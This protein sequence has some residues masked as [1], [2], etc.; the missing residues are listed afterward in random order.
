MKWLFLLVLL[1][2]TPL[3]VALLREKPQ[4]ILF[5]G[6]LIGLAPFFQ[7]TLHLSAS[8]ISW[9]GWPGTV[10]GTEVTLLDAIAVAIILV[11]RPR[12]SPIMLKVGLGM[13]VVAVAISTL[14][15]S[16]MMPSLFYAWQLL[17]SVLVYVAVTRATA[18]Y[19]EFPQRILIGL[20]IGM[21]YEVYL[22]LLQRLHG[23]V[24]AGGSFGHQNQLGMITFFVVF[25]ALALLLA[26][27]R[28]RLAL[29]VVIAEL[30][31]AF[32][33][34]SR[35]VIGLLGAGVVLTIAM[36]IWHRTTGRKATVAVAGALVMVA[37]APVM[38]L[39]IDRRSEAALNSSLDERE[40]FEEA[41]SLIIADHPLGVG[42][43]EYV[44][45]AN[46]GGY[47][48][49][50][51]VPW[52][53]SE[54][55]APVHSAYYLI[56]AEMGWLGLAGF[57]TLL[58][59]IIFTG[60]RALRKCEVSEAS[61]LLVGLVSAAI[62]TTIHFRYEWVP[63]LSH[64]HYLAAINSGMLVGTALTL[65]RR[66]ASRAAIARPGGRLPAPAA[67]ST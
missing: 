31:I 10:K 17:R 47:S 40:A 43:N 15:A 16:Q 1:A 8:A 53:A 4:R 58:L 61:E 42:A 14:M 29:F 49:R 55:S 54:R 21:A 5:L 2:L 52:N 50:A 62:V 59:S 24:Q 22:T 33:G 34:G 44:I 25:P 13:I 39:A 20:A 67:Q 64:I 45:T 66:K 63:M 6:V 32:A 57:L 51:G 11:T 23:A 48:D 46:L 18:M 38:M 30:L 56:T 41:A 36:S 37:A 26:G 65:K 9:A 19:R 35:A 27:K 60:L 7:G 12:R 3:M 28:P